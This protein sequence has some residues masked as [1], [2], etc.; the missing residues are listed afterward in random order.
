MKRSDKAILIALV[1]GLFV[2]CVFTAFYR[3]SSQRRDAARA[4]IVRPAAI[5]EY[6][7]LRA[8]ADPSADGPVPAE[9]VPIRTRDDAT[10]TR[11]QIEAFAELFR[12]TAVVD[13]DPEWGALMDSVN[14]RSHVMYV[15]QAVE[16][17]TD[18]WPQLR[19]LIDSI[20]PLLDDIR[21]TAARGGPVCSL[22]FSLGLYIDMSHL[23]SMRNLARLLRM[24]AIVAREQADTPCIVDDVVA[25]MNLSKALANEPVP[26]SQLVRIAIASTAYDVLRYLP[27]DG[28][29]T[30]Q[31]DRLI[32]AFTDADHR[33]EFA[34]AYGGQAVMLEVFFDNPPQS[35]YWSGSAAN[36]FQAGAF[37]VLSTPLG[38]PVRDMDEAKVLEMLAR[39]QELALLPY[40]EAAPRLAELKAALDDRPWWSYYRGVLQ[41][42]L[43]FERDFNAQA[44]HEETMALARLGLA[45]ERVRTETSAYP[46]SLSE[47]AARFP[48]GIPVSP[49]TGNPFVYWTQDDEFL[50]YGVSGRYPRSS[51]KL[52]QE[53]SNRN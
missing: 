25:I 6:E 38:R 16:P 17:P 4:R 51:E 13:N 49:L 41:G 50:L 28:L 11:S 45:I 14:G 35:A 32:A 18:V 10:A 22:D 24:D 7:Q 39:V 33:D 1:A 48:D 2:A 47:V 27:E 29:D 30:D 43:S 19:A 26:F 42:F 21:T 34:A 8:H 9:P 46:R 15:Q 5:A 36:V 3:M 44:Q 23:N 12:R 20:Q 31:Y 40:W 37:H 53:G 52:W